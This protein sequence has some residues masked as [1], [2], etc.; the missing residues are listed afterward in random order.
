MNKNLP[1]YCSRAVLD[2]IK[3]R[4][5]SATLE[6]YAFPSIP[7]IVWILWKIC[8]DKAQVILIAPN[9]LI[10]FW[11]M[12]LLKLSIHC[13]S[14]SGHSWT[15]N[16][17]QWHCQ[18][19]EPMTSPTQGLVFGWASDLEHFMFPGESVHPQPKQKGFYWETLFM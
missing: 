13:P 3:G 4:C 2:G 14:A 12:D 9:G 5:H 11:F 7:L 15:C 6:G 16:T 19:S 10:H 8:H 18:A 17:T 1:L